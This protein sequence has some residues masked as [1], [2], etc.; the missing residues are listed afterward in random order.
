MDAHAISVVM[1]S[2]NR[3]ALVPVAVESALNQTHL[4][5][6]VIVVVDGPDPASL[7]ALA[8][9]RSDRLKVIA[10]EQSVGA[11]EAR[12]IGVRAAATPWIAFLDDDDTWEPEKLER[13]A[14]LLKTSDLALPIVSCRCRVETA[15]GRFVWP[16]R[17]PAPDEPI[18]DYLFIRRGLYKGETFAPTSTLLFPKRLLELV[19]FDSGVH[20]DW[21]WLV[22]AGARPDCG[23]LMIPEVACVHRAESGI[24]TLSDEPDLDERLAWAS[25]IAGLMSPAA[26]A[27]LILQV[28]GGADDARASFARRF[29]LLKQALRDG[30]RP[31]LM[32][33]LLFLLH[34]AMPVRLRRRLR[35]AVGEA[36]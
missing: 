30:G 31:T 29:Q 4:P 18:A 26:Y 6:E 27:G 15:L 9:I 10:L 13:Q 34:T 5:A 8:A 28:I 2:R 35:P 33:W 1:P 16:R 32:T 12:M 23:M 7:D 3:A 19:P 14:A 36:G 25:S 22:R 24:R 20:D 21:D 17:L 11:A